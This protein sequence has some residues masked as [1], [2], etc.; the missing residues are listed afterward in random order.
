[1]AIKTIKTQTSAKDGMVM[2]FVPAGDF[3]MGSDPVKDVNTAPEEQ[4][5]HTINLK[6]YWIDQTDVTNAM[7]AAFVQATGYKTDAEK[8]GWGWAFTNNAWNKV[9]GADWQHP[10]G[11]GSSLQ[12]L[13]NHPVVLV[14]WA[15]SQA[16]CKWAGRRLPT[17]AEWEK[18]AR[19]TDGRLF[20][21]GDQPPAAN[22]LN[23][24]DKNLPLDWTDK[25]AND[26]YEFTSPVGNYPAGAS[27]YGALDMAGDAIQWVADWFSAK[28]YPTSPMDNPTGPASG[29]SHVVRGGS[30]TN[31]LIS[32]R[33]ASR[34]GD[35]P[36]ERSASLGFRCAVSP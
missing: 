8:G 11:T 30:W 36:D 29:D 32:V 14:S 15:D 19:G 22:L 23:F 25:S 21:W 9:N 27:P 24:A 35:I 28:Y 2:V 4:P 18:A 13:D 16:Y 12:G 10:Q 3:L 20:P 17:E 5:Q 33:S 31:D 6:D 7:Y 26:G 34:S 1:V